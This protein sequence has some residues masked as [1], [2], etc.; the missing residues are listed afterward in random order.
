[1]SGHLR[2]NAFCLLAK[3]ISLWLDGQQLASWL[4]TAE[5]HTVPSSGPLCLC[6]SRRYSACVRL[7]PKR[8]ATEVRAMSCQLSLEELG[9]ASFDLVMTRF[10]LLKCLKSV[11]RKH[12]KESR[13]QLCE[14]ERIQVV[15]DVKT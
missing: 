10:C 2:R 9:H 4:E 6:L 8:E 5:E 15:F 3:E 13:L 14:P 12:G 1:M 7:G 11:P